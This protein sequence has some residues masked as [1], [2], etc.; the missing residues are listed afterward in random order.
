VTSVLDGFTGPCAGCLDT[1]ALV[2][3][4]HHLS[5]LQR[6]RGGAVL[7]R[8]AVRLLCTQESAP[9][10]DDSW[11]RALVPGTGLLVLAEAKRRTTIGGG[12]HAKG[13]TAGCRENEGAHY[14]GAVARSMCGGSPS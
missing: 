5:L 1:A 4:I 14:R 8:A 12:A 10:E 3:K 13:W 9:K 7:A 2:L 6:P 11:A